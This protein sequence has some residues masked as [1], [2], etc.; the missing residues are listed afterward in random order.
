MLSDKV[1]GVL[2]TRAEVV[3]AVDSSCLMHIGGGLSRGRSGVRTGP[4]RGDPRLDRGRAVAVSGF[5]AAARRS[6]ADSQ[7]RANLARATST[8]RDKRAR[9]VAELPDWEE[10]RAAGAAIKDRALLR[11][12]R[13]ARAAGVAGRS[14]PAGRCTGRGTATKRARS[15]P[16]S[17]ART[18]VDEV[19]KVKSIATDEISLNERARRRRRPGGRDRPR[20]ADHPAR[21]RLPVAHPRP[22]DPPQ[23][24][25]DPGHLP[26]R[27]GPRRPHRRAGG[28][29]RGGP[30]APAREVPV[31][32][33]GGER[34]EL[35]GGGDRQRL[36]RR[37]RG[38]RPDVH[39]AA[40]GARDGDG[41]GEGG[42][43][44][45]ATWRSSSSCCRAR[46][47]GSG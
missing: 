20:R 42:A 30:A 5:P 10:L 4:P 18:G 36:R 16:A 43:R 17:R 7:L 35:R 19:V 28:A 15:W 47:P 14:P 25:R 27:A 31:G 8:I 23:P 38:Q 1:R 12:G 13:P 39:D 33:D 45:G 37:V 34:G 29:R 9:V 22:G 6:L 44:A 21:R 26:A 40:R 3:C 11:S 24:G 32:A 2:D 46:R 41:G